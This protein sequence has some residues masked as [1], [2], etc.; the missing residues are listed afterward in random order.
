[1][2]K[3]LR[4]LCG[5]VVFEASGGFCERFLNLCKINNLN[6]WNIKNDGVKVIAFTTA[7]EFTLIKKPARNAG[8]EINVVKE[9]GLPFFIK[10]HKWRCGALAGVFLVFVAVWF[11]SGFIWEVEV[12]T[13]NGVKIENFT[14]CLA[15][16]GVETG[17]R[18]SKID[19]L[20]V[21]ESL[22]DTFSELSWVSINIFGTKA[23]VEYMYAKPQKDIADNIN[24]TNVVSS[25]AG[26]IVHV[27]G[28]AG[29]NVVKIGDCVV[30]GSLLISGVTK[31]ADLSEDL[32][33]ARG[34]VF[35]KTENEICS[36]T[37]DNLNGFLT[38][39]VNSVY[40]LIFF[41]LKIPFGKTSDEKNITTSGSFMLE[42]NH[43]VL[44][45]GV[46]RVDCLLLKRNSIKLKEDRCK[47]I[48]LL[49][50]VEKKRADFADCE[51]QSVQYRVEKN[52]KDLK[53]SAKIICVEN[54]AVEVPFAK[55][56][57]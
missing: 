1:M 57:N 9:C 22:L 7:S 38:N 4:L 36:I 19:V 50:C 24:P 39:K 31:N 45:V 2:I 26:E 42:G 12:V 27:E 21:Q 51:L 13:D 25:K 28:Y 5:Y 8:M 48:N 47:K 37:E 17:A 30:K 54:I 44:P 16:M 18:K 6:L 29:Q 15:D 52:G 46:Q 40:K 11:L 53:V 3:L 56:E 49:H 32:V 14:D 10:R 23:Q 34:K 35:A 41:G 43:V 55:E 20:Q 33:H